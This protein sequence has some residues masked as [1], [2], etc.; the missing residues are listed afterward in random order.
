MEKNPWES[1]KR[2]KKGPAGHSLKRGL[3]ALRF[4]N[5]NPRCF[6][7]GFHVKR[8]ATNAQEFGLKNLEA[9]VVFLYP[10]P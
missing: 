6:A 4:G 2:T 1:E 8:P 7:V 5:L 3:S 10:E 9:A